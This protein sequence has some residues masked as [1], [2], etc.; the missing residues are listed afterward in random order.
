MK[1]IL[2]KISKKIVFSKVIKYTSNN[3]NV[4]LAENLCIN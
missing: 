4:N 3:F 1:P 2:L